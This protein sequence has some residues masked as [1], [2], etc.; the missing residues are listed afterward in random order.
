[1]LVADLLSGVAPAGLAVIGPVV[2][3]LPLAAVA[4]RTRRSRMAV[5]R[6]RE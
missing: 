1:M 6:L 2:M 5:D 4:W 3:G